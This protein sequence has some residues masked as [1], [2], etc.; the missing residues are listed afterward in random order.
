[1]TLQA[2]R[3]SQRDSL[4]VAQRETLGLLAPETTGKSRQDG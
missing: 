3:A 1:M 2:A 4:K